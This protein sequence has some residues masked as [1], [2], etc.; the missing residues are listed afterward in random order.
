MPDII[1]QL[2]GVP[3]LFTDNGDGTYSLKVSSDGSVSMIGQLGGVPVGFVKD[4][5]SNAYLLKVG[6]IASSTSYSYALIT[7]QKTNGTNGGTFT[8]G[9]WRTRD[10]NTILSDVDGIVSVSSNQFTLQAGTYMFFIVVP[11]VEV[12][13]VK[14]GLYNVS[15]SQF[16]LLSEPQFT[17]AG[18][19]YASINNIVLGKITIASQKIFEVRQYCST[20]KATYGFGRTASL[21]EVEYYTRVEIWK[22][23]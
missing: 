22:E 19:T 10:L 17:N 11:A 21:P 5:S 2:G 7:D 8:S 15:D 3:V 9:A 1:G 12:D 18:A 13:F 4:A 16:S 6:G 23:S 14:A 20:S